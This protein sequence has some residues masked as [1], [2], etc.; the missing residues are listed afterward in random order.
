MALSSFNKLV[1]YYQTRVGLDD[2]AFAL[3]FN[4]G[5]G[6]AA[7]VPGINSSIVRGWATY[8]LEPNET[9]FKA[10]ISNFPAGSSDWRVAFAFLALAILKPKLFDLDGGSMWGLAERIVKFQFMNSESARAVLAAVLEAA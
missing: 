5:L 6:T 4:Q 10:I 9:Y 7:E 3:E 1:S 8:D 2:E